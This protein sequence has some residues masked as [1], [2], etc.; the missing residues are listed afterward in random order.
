MRRADFLPLALLAGLAT[1][2]AGLALREPGRPG[3]PPAADTER[4]EN[5]PLVASTSPLRGTKPVAGRPWSGADVASET[6]RSSLAAPGVDAA[7]IRRRLT[8]GASGTYMLSMLEEDS[9]A[10]RWPERP[11]E[12]IRVWV[13]PYSVVPDWRPEYVAVARDAFEHWRAAGI[14]VRVNFLVDSV[15]AEI[16]VVWADRFTDSRIGTTRRFRD[17]H[18]WLVAGDIALAMHHTSGAVIDPDVV[19]AAAI[20]E[21]GH[22]L[23]LNHSPDTNDLMAPRHHSV[24]RPSAADLATMRL[25]YSVPP[26]K[27]K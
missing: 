21:A 19:N 13:E 11:M 17:Q 6:R 16:R 3:T 5:D 4:R 7:E 24:I 12:P 26:G 22:V 27:L 9:G 20:H 23:G 1:V 8:A 25:L 18:W 15:G 10:A 2:V 14:P